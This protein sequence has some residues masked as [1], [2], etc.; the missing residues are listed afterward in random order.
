MKKASGGVDNGLFPDTGA[1]TRVC[2]LRGNSLRNTLD[3]R[4]FQYYIIP[5][6]KHFKVVC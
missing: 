2:L 1:G 5:E 6:F 3:L 4:T